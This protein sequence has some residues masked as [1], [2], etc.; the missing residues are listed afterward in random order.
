[1]RIEGRSSW[2]SLAE[3]ARLADL[4]EAADALLSASGV[5][6]SLRDHQDHPDLDL[7]QE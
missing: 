7:G 2:F 4:V 6:P 1:M 5:S 3:P